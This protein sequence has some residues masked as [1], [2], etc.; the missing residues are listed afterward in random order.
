MVHIVRQP[1]VHGSESSAFTRPQGGLLRVPHHYNQVW[2]SRQQ[3]RLAKDES[4]ASGG[5]AKDRAAEET[6]QQIQLGTE[7]PRPKCRPE[8]RTCLF[9]VDYSQT[10]VAP[11]LVMPIF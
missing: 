5:N 4:F 2:E 9:G 11:F 6:L 3:S 8:D 7:P 1:D 10:R